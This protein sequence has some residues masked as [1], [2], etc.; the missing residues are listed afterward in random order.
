ME[1]RGRGAACRNCCHVPLADAHLPWLSLMLSWP[2]W[3]LEVR[4]ACSSKAT[5]AMAACLMQLSTLH[6]W[7]TSSW[8][9]HGITCP[10]YQRRPAK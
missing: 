3:R 2:P 10:A 9:L 6:A 1:C 4:R 5:V 7:K 8:D